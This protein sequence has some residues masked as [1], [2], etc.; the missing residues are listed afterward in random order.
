MRAW[1]GAQSLAAAAK[2]LGSSVQQAP[3]I[4][5]EG[6]WLRTSTAAQQLTSLRSACTLKD[7]PMLHG[8]DLPV[9]EWLFKP[10]QIAIDE[11]WR[12]VCRGKYMPHVIKSSHA[13]MQWVCF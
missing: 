6:C 3:S 1:A 8:V 5:A 2:L 4:W 11:T 10:L 7:A 12:F 9:S 13:G